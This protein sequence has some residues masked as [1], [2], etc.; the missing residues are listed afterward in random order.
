MK[1][2]SYQSVFTGLSLCFVCFYA[3]LTYAEDD[4]ENFKKNTE[5]LTGQADTLSSKDPQFAEWLRN[6]QIIQQRI[7]KNIKT[8]RKIGTPTSLFRAE[9]EI[10][11]LRYLQK[12]IIGEIDY[13]NN[14]S[15]DTKTINVLDCNAKAD[16]KT[17]NSQAINQA[18]SR[19]KQEGARVIFF[20][21]GDYYIKTGVGNSPTQRSPHIK[22]EGYENI[23]L[24]GEKG[25]RFIFG[26]PTAAG[27]QVD[28]CNNVRLTNVEITYRPLPY[29]IG[30]VVKLAKNGYIVEIAKG[31]PKP[32]EPYFT[33]YDFK[34]LTR[35]YSEKLLPE[36]V[37]PEASNVFSHMAA[38]KV[39]HVSGNQYKF[40]YPHGFPESLVGKHIVFQDRMFGHHGI[41]V[42][43]SKRCRVTGVKIYASPGMAFLSLSSEMT[44][45]NNCTAGPD[46]EFK[47]FASS[48]ADG[49]FVRDALL[50][51]LISGN[52][53]SYIGDDFFN[54]HSSTH[55]AQKI[56]G[57]IVYIPVHFWWKVLKEGQRIG[58]IRSNKGEMH[59]SGETFIKKLEKV[60]LNGRQMYKLTCDKNLPNLVTLDNIPEK[61]RIIPDF[62]TIME[63]QFHGGVVTKNRFSHGLSRILLG[64]RNYLF[65]NNQI[66]DSINHFCLFFIGPRALG[67]LHG[68]EGC[69]PQN[70]LIGGNKITSRAKAVF[71]FGS[72][73]NPYVN[74]IDKQAT[75]HI[76]IA[77]NDIT[78]FGTVCNQPTIVAQDVTCLKIKGNRI[79]NK[80]NTIAAAFEVKNSNYIR[81]AGNNITGNFTRLLW[82]DEGVTNLKQAKN[83]FKP[84]STTPKV[85]KE[86]DFT[87]SQV[88]KQ[89]LKLTTHYVKL[90]DSPQG[91]QCVITG[92]DPYI[93]FP[94]LKP[95]I[96]GAKYGC[97]T[98][99]MKASRACAGKSTEIFWGTPKIGFN[100]TQH[101][102]FPTKL[103]TKELSSFHTYNLPVNW[104]GAHN[105]TQLRLDLFDGVPGG[106]A[107]IIKSIKIT[108]VPQF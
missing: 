45:I 34:G 17:D 42:A 85:C 15:S 46:P 54:T 6:Q 48:N 71:V 33:Q 101:V 92:P 82:N 64:G 9:S 102:G 16:G 98:V 86:W 36:S 108:D 41:E 89:W 5:Q 27:I 87:K 90:M 22:L 79:N 56:E 49:I 70:I 104:Q 69:Q 67:G 65:T 105:V 99:K 44:F 28:Q 88:R 11:D 43:R 57:N 18:L 21:K 77:N 100:A 19:A 35:F 91:L 39:K 55:P 68:G 59:V 13:L 25:T 94:R 61:K 10:N 1:R 58:W 30:K 107:V 83:I 52:S 51:G 97:V 31:F 81:I 78:L 2:F 32:T 47:T 93:V 8:D 60:D 80:C 72:R 4:L 95:G 12:R 40:E 14:L 96:D 103:T 73:L 106:T 74:Y 62:L 76:D 66:D 20:P 53:I 37:R 26:R 7:L 3:T 84:L 29:T 75:T 50:G 23:E 24:K 38:P 63:N